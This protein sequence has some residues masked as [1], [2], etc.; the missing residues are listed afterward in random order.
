MVLDIFEN[1]IKSVWLLLTGHLQLSENIHSAEHEGIMD[2]TFP[3]L[4]Q[5]K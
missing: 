5:L 1:L 3:V 2:L 4:T